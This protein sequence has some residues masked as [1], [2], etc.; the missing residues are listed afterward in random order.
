MSITVG[1]LL[2]IAVSAQVPDTIPARAA[3]PFVLRATVQGNT[4]PQLSAPSVPGATIQLVTDVTRLGGGFGQAVATREMR[5][6]LRATAPGVLQFGAVVATLG[7]Q[8]AAST[9]KQVVVLPPPTN[10]VPAIVSRAALTRATL[11][12]FHSLV[13]PDTV[14]AGEQVTLQVGVFI[15]DE[16]RAQLQRNPE[17]I[18]PSVDGAVA[19]ELPVLN[20]ELPSRD[21][22]GVRYRPFVFARALFPLRAGV[23]PIPP[24]RLVY[25]L[26]GAG[27][28]FGRQDRKAAVT[29]ARSVVVRE[30]P[31][32]GRLASFAGAVG[33]YTV[34]AQ[35]ERPTGR[36]GDAVLLSVRVD[37]TGNVKLLP[38]PVLDI[39]GAIVSPSGETIAVDSSDLIVRGSKTFRYLVTPRTE[40]LLDL[41][42]VRYPYF[43]PVQG[44]Y[45]EATAPAGALRV[46]AGAAPEVDDEEPAADALPLLRWQVVDDRDVT[47]TWWYRAL[48]VGLGLPWLA[49]VVRRA[50]HRVR[51]R[52][53]TGASRGPQAAGHVA[54]D[55]LAGLRRRY[56][57][58]LAPMVLLRRDEPFEVV[59]VVRRLRR[60]GVTTDA[61]EAA[62][63]LLLRLD[64]LTFGRSGPIDAAV[65]RDLD[66]EVT[67]VAE[68]LRREISAS[69]QRRLAAI[70][71]ALLVVAL[72]LP[73]TGLHAQPSSFASGLAAYRHR[74]FAAA[75]AAFARA[76]AD[77][78]RSVAAWT[79][80]GAAHW[81]RAD[82]AGAIVAWQRSVRLA[83]SGG[84]AREW[85]APY[86]AGGEL[87]TAIVPVAP[88]TAWLVLLGVGAL[89][90][91]GGALW[92]WSNRR[93]SNRALL[94]ATFVVCGCALLCLAAER[95]AEAAGLVVIRREVA[96]RSEPALAGET[97]ARARGGELATVTDSSETWRRLS[98]AGGRS[99]WVEVDALRSLAARD[100]R[101]VA[102]A[103]AR[104]ADGPVP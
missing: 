74:D 22:D 7:T 19:Y 91:L 47:A 89:L 2:Q 81:M 21:V 55:G 28:M 38:P 53:H 58:V 90:S 76:A 12:N 1:V 95:S 100:A 14:W 45:E 49:L 103:E 80:L 50:W 83:P 78:P 65:L 16:L 98:L 59:E 75:V 35:L 31:V 8:R 32:A 20:D 57:D 87:R 94:G 36:V 62:G 71:G 56:L 69:G 85:L 97:G 43:N 9:P 63:A 73:A 67:S 68:Q 37:G 33:V 86:T 30:L 72:L 84:R 101:D 26:G 70:S 10:A 39:P 4:A 104:T 23:L 96:L 18:A 3:V 77:E 40:G 79:N 6:V 102:R 54:D 99:G 52:R 64:L 27:T 93:I 60:A 41:G 29:P 15:D 48:A 25:T 82:T 46:A 42:V 92:R 11:V 66:R 34:R 51:R 61:S 24:A 17:Y 13:T 44:R 88:G 5:Y